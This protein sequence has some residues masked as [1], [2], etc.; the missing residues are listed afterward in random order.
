[1]KLVLPLPAFSWA[2][3]K[4]GFKSKHKRK[5]NDSED[6]YRQGKAQAQSTVVR[7]RSIQA[8][9]SMYSSCAYAYFK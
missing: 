6:V 8:E 1:M 2:P 7:T 5:L 9:K 4:N 3:A